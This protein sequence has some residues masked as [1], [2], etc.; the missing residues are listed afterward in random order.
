MVKKFL[1]TFF[2]EAVYADVK[3]RPYK[4]SS[5]PRSQGETGKSEENPENL[6]V[7]YS[8]YCSYFAVQGLP[9]F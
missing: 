2:S 8:D 3:P 1:H 4:R 7:I 5:I 9:Q 6:T